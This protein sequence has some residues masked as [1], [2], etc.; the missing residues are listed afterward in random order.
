MKEIWKKINNYQDYEISNFGNVRS[1]KNNSVRILKPS[2]SSSGYLQVILCQDSGTKSHFI[3]KLVAQEFLENENDYCEVN[4]KDENKTNNK[5]ENLEWCT[6]KY[7]MNYGTIKTKQSKIKM[8]K[9]AKMNKDNQIIEIY[10][11]IKEAAKR[12]NC[13]E[14][15][16]VSCCKNK[17]HY[18]THKGFKWK[19][20]EN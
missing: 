17:K 10:E 7:N 16:I 19:Y 20:I 9:V 1:L 8:K 13:I 18:N 5:V 3:H 6:R 15:H 4:H 12:N 2:K 11:S 14:T